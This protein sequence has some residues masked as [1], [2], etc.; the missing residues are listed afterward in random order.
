MYEE[1]SLRKL[2]VDSNQ[3]AWE[4]EEGPNPQ[5]YWK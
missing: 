3:E 2:D 4:F 5:E 1:S